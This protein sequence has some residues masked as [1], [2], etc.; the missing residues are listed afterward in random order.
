MQK[1]FCCIIIWRVA[2]EVELGGTDFLDFLPQL[3][4]FGANRCE[5]DI[6]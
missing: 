5:R 6:E 2:M 1:L 3:K 4:M